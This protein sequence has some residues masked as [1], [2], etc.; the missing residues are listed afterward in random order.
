MDDTKFDQPEIMGAQGSNSDEHHWL[1]PADRVRCSRSWLDPADPVEHL[2]SRF[3]GQGRRR[4][5]GRLVQ[6]RA[7]GAHFLA[8]LWLT[9]C[10]AGHGQSPW[11]TSYRDPP[12]L[13]FEHPPVLCDVRL[14][15]EAAG[16]RKSPFAA[17][18][19]YLLSLG[20][21]PPPSSALIIIVIILSL[22]QFG[23]SLFI[24]SSLLRGATCA[25]QST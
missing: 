9:K 24:K 4:K 25:G 3:R 5:H 16:Q 6:I 20:L 2:E 8:K 7:M 22:V 14:F 19:R 12:E 11:S 1:D 23:H 21:R 15:R 10:R 17:S 18:S 13:R